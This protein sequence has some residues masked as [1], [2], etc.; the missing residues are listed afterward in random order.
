MT[1]ILY[2]PQ[3]ETVVFLSHSLEGPS[4]AEVPHDI[5]R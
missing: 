3:H 2:D 1:A 5:K 4:K